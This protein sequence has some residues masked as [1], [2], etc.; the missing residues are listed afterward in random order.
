M[1]ALENKIIIS[2]RPLSENDSLKQHLSEKGAWVLDFPM[3]E[4]FP[5]ELS[6]EEIQILRKAEHFDWIVF[7]SGN[8]VNFFFEA[9][10]FLGIQK[11]AL[12]SSKIAVVGKKTAEKVLNHQISPFL[13]SKGNNAADLLVEIQAQIQPHES[14]LLVLG[15]L[16][17]G[18]FEEGL[19]LQ[20]AVSR[21]NIYET[22][23]VANCSKNIVE[24]IQNNS[25][26]LIIFTSPSGFRNFLHIMKENLGESELKLACIGKTTEIE[27][28]KNGYAPLLVSSKSEA[29]FFADEIEKY[30][31][32][33]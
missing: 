5:A 13:I 4:V 25:Y 28:K 10:Q 17:G 27:L 12:S 16:A 26:D 9:L 2:T 19:A 18:I 31:K 29:V 20:H 33:K 6:I 3:I 22:K 14:V 21:I 11:S 32:T 7:T 8:G 23:A 15:K 24:R 30:F 1:N